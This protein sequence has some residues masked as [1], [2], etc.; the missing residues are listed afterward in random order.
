MTMKNRKSSIICITTAILAGFLAGCATMTPDARRAKADTIINDWTS[1]S[2]L[3]AAKLIEEYGPPDRIKN[4]ELTWNEKGSWKRITVRDVSGGYYYYEAGA[5][6]IE[7]AISCR[8]PS[9]KRRALAVFSEKIRVPPGGIELI[10]RSKREEFNFLTVNLAYEIIQGI[11]NPLEAQRFYDRTLQL[12][13]AG[14]SSPYM[15]KLLFPT[16]GRNL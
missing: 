6:N 14:K 8:V 1:F 3:A 13:V 5:Y 9:E 4:D 12:T 11:R 2:R 10:V 16:L 15:N 7:Q